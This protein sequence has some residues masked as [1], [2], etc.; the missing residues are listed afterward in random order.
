MAIIAFQV[1]FMEEKD[2]KVKEDSE[3]DTPTRE[4]VWTQGPNLSSGRSCESRPT[5]QVLN[6]AWHIVPL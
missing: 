4:Q 2:S 1:I 3:E 5:P 6:L